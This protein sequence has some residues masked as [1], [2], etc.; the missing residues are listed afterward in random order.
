MQ[1]KNNRSSNQHMQMIKD[2]LPFL[3]KILSAI[4]NGF[5]DTYISMSNLRSSS[6]N[7]NYENEVGVRFTAPGGGSNNTEILIA[8]QYLDKFGLFLAVGYSKATE[9]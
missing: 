7:D 6:S 1:A 8:Q 4:E 2:K 3:L 9:V 5:V